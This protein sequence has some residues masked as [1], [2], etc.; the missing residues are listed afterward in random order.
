MVKPM[1]PAQKQLAENHMDLVP[2]IIRSLTNGSPL[3]SEQRQELCQIGYLALCRAAVSCGE[4][5]PFAPYAAAAIRNAVY[6]FWRHEIRGKDLFCPLQED[7]LDAMPALQIAQEQEAMPDAAPLALKDTAAGAYLETLKASQCSTIQKASKPSTSSLRVTRPRSCPL[8]TRCLPT[9]SGPGRAKPA[10]FTAGCSAVRSVIL[11]DKG[12]TFMLTL[13][14][15]VGSLQFVNVNGKPVPHVINNQKEYGMSKEELLV[16]SC[17]AFQILTYPELERLFEKNCADSGQ[18]ISL[19]L[20]HYL[21]RLLLRGLLVKGM[22]VSA[23]DALYRLLGTLTIT[24]VED[25]FLPRLASVFLLYTKGQVRLKDIPRLLRKTKC[26]PTE[27]EVLALAG[28]APLSTAELL[29]SMERGILIRKEEDILEKLYTSPEDTCST[30][31]DTVQI[32]HAQYPILQA[33]SN[34]YLNQKILFQKI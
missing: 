23:V 25:R 22:G 1:T 34:L 7:L 17:L 31:T 8:T 9:T 26:T 16:W 4:G 18:S 28:K 14:T 27:R 15:A 2:K 30:L 13:Y 33:V 32:T 29:L 21:N 5:F 19:P 10:D 6:D 20:S 12:G 24:P 11:N 3:T